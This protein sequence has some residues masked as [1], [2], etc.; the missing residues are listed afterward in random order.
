MLRSASPYSSFFTS[1]LLFEGFSTTHPFAEDLGPRRGSLPNDMPL[2]L[3]S[4]SQKMQSPSDVSSAFYFTLQ[5][6]RDTIALRSFL[7]LDL[8]ESQS[9][10]SASLHRNDSTVTKSTSSRKP[11]PLHHTTPLKQIIPSPKPMPSTTPP[12]VP[13]STFDCPPVL[14]PIIPSPR[15]SLGPELHRSSSFTSTT[16][17]SPSLA[18]P[19]TC[20]SRSI[21]ATE[22]R[23]GH[24]DALASL[25]GRAG[26]DFMDMGDDGDD[27]QITTPFEQVVTIISPRKPSGRTRK[28]RSTMFPLASFIDL[29][30]DDISSWNWRSFIEVGGAS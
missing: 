23:L 28:R 8:A 7:S 21:T 1:G 12:D 5:P 30:D 19:T 6:R 18:P 10:R 13:K 20:S 14:P 22:R 11:T 17:T 24:E 29:K 2:S 4:T 9:I 27:G 3:C 15:L 25:E 16:L 26:D